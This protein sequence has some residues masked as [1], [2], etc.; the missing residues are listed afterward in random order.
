MTI[1]IVT[2]LGID[3]N[4]IVSPLLLITTM[5]GIVDATGFAVTPVHGKLNG[6]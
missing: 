3:T 5:I 1:V 2:V 4:L 6:H